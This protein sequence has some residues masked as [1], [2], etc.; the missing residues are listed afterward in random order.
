MPQTQ[1]GSGVCGLRQANLRGVRRRDWGAS[2]LQT[3]VEGGELMGEFD[4]TVISLGAGV[5]SSCMYLMAV[6]GVLPSADVA[7]FAD[8]QSEPMYVKDQ[9]DYLESVGGDVIPIRR[10]TKG[11]LR[12]AVMDLG[13]TGFSDAPFW[14]DSDEKEAPGRRQCTNRFKVQVL[15]QAIRA[16]LGI[17]FRQRAVGRVQVEKWI[18]LSMD[19]ADMAT[20]P[21]HRVYKSITNRWPLL[22]DVPM[23]RG[24]CEDW[25]VSRGH[26]LPKASA[27][28]FCPFLRVDQFRAMRDAEPEAFEDAVRVDAAIRNVGKRP[29]FVHRSRRPL[30]E[31]VDDPDYDDNQIAL[32]GAECT[33]FCGT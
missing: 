26:P 32:F 15:I 6:E 18:G 25:M 9:L 10:V 1:D 13:D 7:I 21:R 29:Q 24:E 12:D 30:R 3:E 33:G 16:E 5:Q 28:T 22:Y 8:T 19:E 20:P 31:V 11:S 17:K 23:R 2:G 14:V 27:C 4:L